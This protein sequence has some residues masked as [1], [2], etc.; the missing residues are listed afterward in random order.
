MTTLP[1]NLFVS[2]AHKD[3]DL[4]D[5]LATHLKLLERQ[6][7]ISSWHD[8]K[9]SPG[10]DWAKDIDENLR[11]ADIVL[12][13][14]S[15]DFLASDYC[16]DEE[17]QQALA[18]HKSGRTRVVPVVLRPCDWTSAPF[19]NLQALPI[20]HGAGAKPVTIWDDRDEAFLAIAK[21]IRQVAQELRTFPSQERLFSPPPESHLLSTLDNLNQTLKTMSDQPQPSKYSFPKAENVQIIEKIDT[22]NEHNYATPQDLTAAAQDIQQ[23]LDQLASTYAGQPD[24]AIVTRDVQAALD[25]NPTLKARLK[26]A[27]KAGSIETVKAIFNHP[28]I[29]IPI[30]TIKGFLEAE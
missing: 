17:L 22:Y 6:G 7:V 5:Q 18:N 25:S 10:T 20:A 2:Y 3:E 29:S 23:L 1:L 19:G 15:S 13:L 9:I 30:E 8:R 16:Y 21:G 28:A 24:P 27:L 12:L 11:T 26:G 4:R 14:I